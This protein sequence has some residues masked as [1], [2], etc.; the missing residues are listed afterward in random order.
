MNPCEKAR[1]GNT[2]I[3]V[4]RLG[5]GAG[6]LGGLY[7]EVPDEAAVALVHGALQSG[8]NY[9]DTAP[10]YGHGKSETRLARALAGVPRDAYVLSS[11]VGRLL[12]PEDPAKVSSQWFENPPPF[13]PVFDF[14][15]D[16]VKKSLESSLER[17]QL[18]RV[19]ILFIHDPDRHVYDEVM[20]GAYPALRDLRRQG[21]VRAIGVACWDP[22]LVLRF[23]QAGEFDAFMLP[24]RYTLLD[25]S[26]HKELL[27]F[28][29]ETGAGVVVA[30]PF[31][32]GILATGAKPGAKFN[33]EDATP[34]VIETVQRMEAICAEYGVALPAAALQFPLGHPAVAAVVAGA[35][36]G[37]ELALN[38]EHLKQPIPA[39]FWSAMVAAGIVP[40]DAPLPR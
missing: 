8:L 21:V 20:Q 32:S 29:I 9:V 22:E 26:A 33:Y 3:E 37:A 38:L 16:A 27:P 40:Q 18:D 13:N 39:A 23:A 11:K 10:L 19:D 24:G 12:V 30:A 6:V 25:Q 35:R 36:T 4:T 5:L 31:Y 34:E 14:S 2:G 7:R 1:L 15:Y 17:L 28:C